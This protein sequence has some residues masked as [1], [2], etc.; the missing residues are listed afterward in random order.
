MALKAVMSLIAVDVKS[1]K[2]AIPHMP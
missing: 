2:P 1:L